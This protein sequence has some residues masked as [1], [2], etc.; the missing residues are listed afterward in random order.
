MFILSRYRGREHSLSLSQEVTLTKSEVNFN[1]PN[2]FFTYM[3]SRIACCEEEGKQTRA[4]TKVLFFS[5]VSVRFLCALYKIDFIIR[6]KPFWARQKY[7][8]FGVSKNPVQIFLGVMESEVLCYD[9]PLDGNGFPMV[10][11][12]LQYIMALLASKE[13]IPFSDTLSFWVGMASHFFICAFT[14]F[15]LFVGGVVCGEACLWF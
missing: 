6:A 7:F 8:H 12:Y 2:L 1:H 15:C 13:F 14:G 11:T 10:L 3:L 4:D 5:C 9:S